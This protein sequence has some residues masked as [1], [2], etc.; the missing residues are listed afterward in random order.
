MLLCV[1]FA[2][3]MKEVKLLAVQ[4]DATTPSIVGPTIMQPVHTLC[5]IFLFVLFKNIGERARTSVE[6]ELAL[7]VNKSPAVYVL[8]RALDGL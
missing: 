3:S 6:R 8:S 1:V 5:F 2:Q 7:A 4:T